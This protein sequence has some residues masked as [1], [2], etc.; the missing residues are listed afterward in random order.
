[1]VVA[2][3]LTL[4]GEAPYPAN[5]Q[6]ANYGIR[7]MKSKARRMERGDGS[8]ISVYRQLPRRPESI[9]LRHAPERRA[10]QCDPLDGCQ[11]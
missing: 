10:L 7:W 9:L 2:I 3:D 11:G 1:M 5:V 8:S 4:S 6:D